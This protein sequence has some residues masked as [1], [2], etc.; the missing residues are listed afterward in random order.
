MG[1]THDKSIAKMSNMVGE[2]WARREASEIGYMM[3]EMLDL[4]K[5]SKGDSI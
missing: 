2:V 4:G 5:E 3:Y 1:G